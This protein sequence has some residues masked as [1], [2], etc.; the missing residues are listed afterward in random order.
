MLIQGFIGVYRVS[1]DFIGI[2][3]VLKG[4]IGFLIGFCRGL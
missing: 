4:F 2:Y 3:M 1:Q